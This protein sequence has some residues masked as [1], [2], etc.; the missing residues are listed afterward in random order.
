[1]RRRI[2]RSLL[3]TLASHG[4]SQEFCITSRLI[5][6]VRIRLNY[7]LINGANRAEAANPFKDELSGFKA[8]RAKTRSWT[9]N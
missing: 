3:G 5:R 8:T 9:L 2:A 4:R 7:W 6:P 1:V